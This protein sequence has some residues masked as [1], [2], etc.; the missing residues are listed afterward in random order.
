MMAFFL[1]SLALTFL[2]VYAAQEMAARQR[3]SRKGWMWA[4]ALLGPFPL[5]ILVCLPMKQTQHA[6]EG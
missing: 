3:R 1:V 5:L 2:C 4:A 6:R